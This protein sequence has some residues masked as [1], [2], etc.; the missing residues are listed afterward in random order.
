MDDYAHHPTAIRTTLAGLRKFYPGR[1]IV[2]DFMSHTYSR[3]T[4]LLDEFA[5]SFSSADIVMLH[6]IYAS[7]REINPGG[8]SGK[9]LYEKARLLH[10]RVLY[11]EE[12]FDAAE[13]LKKELK[14]GDLFITL[15][16]GDNWHLSKAL[17][18]EFCAAEKT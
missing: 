18:G 16:A 1:R 6:K 2:A 8:I 13:Y 12:V 3:T 9:D 14:E 7:A 11:S 4:A 15:G 5:A 10:P 17:Y